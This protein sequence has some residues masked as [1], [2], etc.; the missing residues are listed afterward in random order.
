MK[1]HLLSDDINLFHALE[2]VDEFQVNNIES[3]DLSNADVFIVSDRIIHHNDLYNFF[4]K[5]NRLVFY[6]VSNQ[7]DTQLLRQV[8]TICDSL[9][10]HVIQPRLTEE[11]ITVAIYQTIF[12]ERKGNNTNVVA[13]LSP[14]PNIG[15]TSSTLSIAAAI[16]S[17]TNAKVGVIGNNAW[18]DGTDQIDNYKGKFL[19]EIKTQLTNRMFDKESFLNAFH[20]DEKLPFYYLA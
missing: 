14:I 2:R 15:V 10:I 5:H 16:Q 3:I 8:K 18:D 13:V 11:Q 17:M 7:F 19:D 9:N 20:K 1:V 12:P 6:L 4:S